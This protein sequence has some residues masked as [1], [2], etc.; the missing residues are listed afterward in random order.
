MR[1]QVVGWNRRGFTLIELMIVVAIIGILAA[2][3][4][5]S[6]MKFQAKAKQS[7]A[8]TNLKALFTAEKAYFGERDA[9]NKEFSIVGFQP[10]G[11]NRYNYIAGG[12]V[13]LQD[14]VRFPIPTTPPSGMTVTE[15]NASGATATGP[16]VFG[17]C[18]TCLFLAGAYGNIDND[19]TTDVWAVGSDLLT[20]TVT[21]CTPQPSAAGGVPLVIN[22]DVAC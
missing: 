15:T 17:T 10:E 7:E 3:A 1:Q 11:G 4:V 5:P 12:T 14:S 9:F 21:T 16:G 22:D 2:I 8:K 20:Q 19:A 6:F 13:I 18:P